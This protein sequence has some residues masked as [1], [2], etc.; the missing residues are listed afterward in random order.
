MTKKYFLHYN[1]SRNVYEVF[2][3]PGCDVDGENYF[4]SAHV[5][6]LMNVIFKFKKQQQ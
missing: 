1:N 6:D 3:F 2:F 4:W 5:S